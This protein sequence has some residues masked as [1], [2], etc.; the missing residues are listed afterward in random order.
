MDDQKNIESGGWYT[1]DNECSRR[2][3]VGDVFEIH[4]FPSLQLS[5][6]S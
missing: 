3:Y 6:M 1:T 5:N 2:T 4:T